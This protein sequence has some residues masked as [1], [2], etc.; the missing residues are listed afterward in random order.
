MFSLLDDGQTSLKG[1]SLPFSKLEN[2]DNV[3][4]TRR[5][6]YGRQRRGIIATIVSDHCC[7][8]QLYGD[9]SDLREDNGKCQSQILLIVWLIF[10]EKVHNSGKYSKKRCNG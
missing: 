7:V 10:G 5:K 8:G 3:E 4:E 6:R 9:L 1:C 2:E